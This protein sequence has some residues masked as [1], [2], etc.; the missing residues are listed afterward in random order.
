MKFRNLSVW[1]L[2]ISLSSFVVTPASAVVKLQSNSKV[3]TDLKNRLFREQAIVNELIKQTKKDSRAF[4]NGTGFA[5]TAATAVK[6]YLISEIKMIKI[7]SNKSS[8]FTPEKVATVRT[9]L[10]QANELYK[11]FAK[12][13]SNSSGM[14]P[15]LK[16]FSDLEASN[17]AKLLYQK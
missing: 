1:I 8:C 15:A 14:K 13:D 12:I 7:A 4:I 6:T 3:C 11:L 2:L 5:S 10:T 16:A 17:F 9:R